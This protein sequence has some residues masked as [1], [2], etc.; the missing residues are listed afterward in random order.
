MPDPDHIIFP[1][2][3]QDSGKEIVLRVQGLLVLGKS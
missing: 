1:G 3:S 2:H